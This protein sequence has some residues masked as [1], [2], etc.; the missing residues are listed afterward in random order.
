MRWFV[1]ASVAVWSASALAADVSDGGVIPLPPVVG[2]Q[3]FSINE[4]LTTEALGL[5]TDGKAGFDYL[6]RRH[7]LSAAFAP[8][9]KRQLLPGEALFNRFCDSSGSAAPSLNRRARDPTSAA[10]SAS[11]A[12]PV[13]PSS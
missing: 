8:E 13:P 7:S 2:A 6:P 10:N 3:R 9:L 1:V 12:V 4:I 11:S 5:S